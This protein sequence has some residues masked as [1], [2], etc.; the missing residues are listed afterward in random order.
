MIL[1]HRLHQQF[2][3]NVVVDHSTLGSSRSDRIRVLT[4]RYVVVRPPHVL[5]RP[6]NLSAVGGR[7]AGTGHRHRAQAPRDVVEGPI[8]APR[9]G[10]FPF[11]LAVKF[12]AVG[13]DVI[14]GS[15]NRQLGENRTIGWPSSGDSERP[16]TKSPDKN[17]EFVV[18]GFQAYLLGV[19][20]GEI[21]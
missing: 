15:A 21:V 6:V 4:V 3:Q 5:A 8:R 11:S 9:R 7:V 14:R 20:V 10:Q 16:I 12:G 19:V 2:D 13:P 17:N 1:G 18:G